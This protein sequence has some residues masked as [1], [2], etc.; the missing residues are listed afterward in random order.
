M[1]ILAK[2][3]NATPRDQLKGLS[4][5]QDSFWKVSPVSNLPALL[6]ALPSLVPDGAILYI[7]GGSPPK[8]IKA[9]LDE[10]CVPEV[11]HLAMGT[12]WPKPAV[13]HLPATPQNLAQLAML[14]EKCATAEVAVHLHIYQPGKVL[15]EWYDAFFKDP[16]YLSQAIPEER[17]KEFCKLLSL[18]Y[19][20]SKRNVEPPAG[21]SNRL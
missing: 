19:K 2:L 16:L 4:L 11:S 3:F 12:I 7:E 15:L 18:T 8:E 1:G 9:F 13:F 20:K 10:H 6:K 21:A 5:G 14:A 17:V